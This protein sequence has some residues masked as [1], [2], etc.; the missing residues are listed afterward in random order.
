MFLNS[1]PIVT[2]PVTVVVDIV[3]QVTSLFCALQLAPLK[4]IQNVLNK[5]TIQCHVCQNVLKRI[6]KYE[7]INFSRFK[8]WA[9]NVQKLQTSHEH[10]FSL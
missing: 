1:K 10:S 8:Q 9:V 3:L 7:D 2:V 6:K 4:Q 5:H